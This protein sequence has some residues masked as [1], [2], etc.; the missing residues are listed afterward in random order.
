M[1]NNGHGNPLVLLYGENAFDMVLKKIESLKQNSNFMF[2]GDYVKTAISFMI[3]DI[4]KIVD[5]E[6]PE[7][8]LDNLV[9]KSFGEAAIY[10]FNC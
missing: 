4:Q 5:G 8:S 10:K 9:N 7:C 6:K 2:D 1:L 3:I